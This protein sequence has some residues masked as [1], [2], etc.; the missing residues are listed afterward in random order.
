MLDRGGVHV[1]VLE[2]DQ[3]HVKVYKKHLTHT[4]SLTYTLARTHTR[5]RNTHTHTTPTP[6]PTLHTPKLHTPSHA[7]PHLPHTHTHT[8]AHAKA[9]T[10]TVSNA[11]FPVRGCMLVGM[12]LPSSVIVT[13]PSS[14]SRS[15]SIT[16]AWPPCTCRLP[17]ERETMVSSGASN[18]CRTRVHLMIKVQLGFRFDCFAPA[19]CQQNRK[20]C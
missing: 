5:T 13:Q 4:Y 15:T 18:A 1:M 3:R 20:Q 16:V 2:K 6:T 19:G 11:D 10:R 12:P 9:Y 14:R 7:H 8:R 17:A